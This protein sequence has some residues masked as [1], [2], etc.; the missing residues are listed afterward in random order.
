MIIVRAPLRISFVGGGTDLPDFYRVSP[1]RVI[2]TA[3]DR[4]VFVAINPTPFLNEKITVRYS[5]CEVVNHPNELKNDRVR[6]ALLDLGILNN[7]DITTFSHV[8]AKTGLGGSSS[9]SVALIKALHSYLGRK[10]DERETAEA[11]SRLEIELLGEPIGKQDQY[12]SAIGG[13]NIIQFNPDET[14]D[15]DP[16]FLDY[17]HRLD[18]QNQLLLFFTGISRDAS[19]V[20]TKQRKNITN[21]LETLK[22]MAEEPL[23]FKERLLK[24]DFKGLGEMLHK[25]W[26]EK[27]TLASNVSNSI[28]NEFYDGGMNEGAWGGKILGAGGGGCVLFLTPSE[29]REAIR[30]KMKE[31]VLKNNLTEFRE[32][33][34]KFVQSGVEVLINHHA[35]GR[36]Y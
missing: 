5:I 31:V 14:V 30:K 8:S 25:G 21:R 15:V 24:K 33:P 20:L 1:G 18:F 2:S 9:F 26:L 10:I 7:I 4:Y 19:F 34:V 13:L 6:A 28:I 35:N 36:I 16:V 27:K 12:A 23:E 32:I 29:K 11:A 22:I 17:K 3:I